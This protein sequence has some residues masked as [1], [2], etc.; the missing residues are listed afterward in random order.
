MFDV[1]CRVLVLVTRFPGCVGDESTAMAGD[2]PVLPG[3]GPVPL[4]RTA[5]Y[6]LSVALG[7]GAAH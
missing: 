3:L 7:A 5:L 4:A 6:L 1:L 2:S